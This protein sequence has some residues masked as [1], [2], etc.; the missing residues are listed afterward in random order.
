MV[1]T[2]GWVLWDLSSDD[3]NEL[4]RQ[5]IGCLETV[6]SIHASLTLDSGLESFTDH[7]YEKCLE[8]GI[9]LHGPHPG[10]FTSDEYGRNFQAGSN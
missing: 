5:F 10:D 1:C 8:L 6:K 3:I 4:D 2:R 7:A 9:D